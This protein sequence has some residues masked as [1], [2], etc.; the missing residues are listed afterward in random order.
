MTYSIF[1]YLEGMLAVHRSQIM[2]GCL[3][4]DPGDTSD[5]NGNCFA[6]RAMGSDRS[7]A[8]ENILGP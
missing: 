1:S 7:V 4:A 6:W 3:Q 8:S 2:M 5:I